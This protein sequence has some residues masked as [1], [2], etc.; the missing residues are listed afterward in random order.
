MAAAMGMPPGDSMLRG[1][2]PAVHEDAEMQYPE[3]S[4]R[5][6]HLYPEASYRSGVSGTQSD[7]AHSGAEN[8]VMA[9]KRNYLAIRKTYRCEGREGALP[10]RLNAVIPCVFTSRDDCA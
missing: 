10:S 2:I 1:A 4:I 5:S 7:S 6:G 8:S 9:G 3:D